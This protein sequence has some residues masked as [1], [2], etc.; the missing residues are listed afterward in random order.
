[1]SE[2]W[3]PVTERL[4]ENL[5]EVIVTWVNTNPA[6][7][8]KDIEG[9]PFCGVAVFYNDD[10]Y[11]YSSFTREDLEEYGMCENKL[12]DDSIEITAWMPFP[13]PY[14]EEQK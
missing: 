6:S 4:P 3:I 12:I 10:W 1:M 5:D 2:K 9:K 8:Y 7:Y 13:E 11:W 14:K